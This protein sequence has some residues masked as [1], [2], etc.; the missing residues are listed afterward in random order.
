MIAAA[1]FDF[2]EQMKSKLYQFLACSL[3]IISIFR[4][5]CSFPSAFILF[6][7]FSSIVSF[8]RITKY[9]DGDR[10]VR[11]NLHKP[12]WAAAYAE[13]QT[14]LESPQKQPRRS[15]R[16]RDRK[17]KIEQQKKIKEEDVKKLPSSCRGRLQAK[18]N[19]HKSAPGSSTKKSNEVKF[20]DVPVAGLCKIK[21]EKRPRKD[22]V[23]SNAVVGFGVRSS[24]RLRVKKEPFRNDTNTIEM[25]M[26]ESNKKLNVKAHK[27]PRKSAVAPNS[28]VVVRS[29]ERLR[30]KQEP[31]R[32]E[33]RLIEAAILEP[34]K[35]LNAQTL[36]R[37]RKDTV[38]THAFI[39]IGLRS[40]ERLRIKKENLN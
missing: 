13:M 40:S 18:L 32:N 3:I 25:A 34:N 28:V 7:S 14:D 15:T 1:K 29:S 2:T 10:I 26:I 23:A 6:T 33:T 39:G 16:L 12:A 27:R 20:A 17:F 9:A 4:I 24:E 37:P 19:A 31:F 35:K 11:K 38:L 36:R 8:D 21:T 22:A 5:V 30:L